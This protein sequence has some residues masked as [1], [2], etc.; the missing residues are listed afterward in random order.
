[1]SSIERTPD[2]ELPPSEE[3]KKK[4]TTS[5]QERKA[6]FELKRKIGGEAGELMWDHEKK[7]VFPPGTRKGEFLE[8][9]VWDMRV[10]AILE[11]AALKEEIGSESP[12]NTK[13]KEALSELE[14]ERR[15]AE[16]YFSELPGWAEQKTDE[17]KITYLKRVAKTLGF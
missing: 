16:Q 1:M 7:L 10:E 11:Y 3:P 2:A 12:S 5:H 8:K 4:K 17:E 14:Q 6:R 15:E 9:K 13:K